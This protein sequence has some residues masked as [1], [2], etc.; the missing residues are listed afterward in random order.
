MPALPA[1]GLVLGLLRALGGHLTLFK[2]LDEVGELAADPEDWSTEQFA[3][4]TVVKL[5]A[6]R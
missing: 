6:V 1:G 3:T 2:G 4:M 5:T